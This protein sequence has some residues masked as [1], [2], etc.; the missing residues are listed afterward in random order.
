QRGETVALLAL[1]DS[2]APPS[3]QQRPDDYDDAALLPMFASYLGARRG[4]QL[5]LDPEEFPALDLSAR[6]GQVL[7]KAKAAEALPS[8]TDVAQI[9]QPLQIYKNGLRR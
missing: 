1:F 9:K 3:G 5:L 7:E 2:P 4:K 8:D 6:F